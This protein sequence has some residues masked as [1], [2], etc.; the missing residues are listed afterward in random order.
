MRK[1]SSFKQRDVRCAVAAAIEAGIS[2]AR[3]EVGRDGVIKIIAGK[4]EE[5]G[6]DPDRNEWDEA[7]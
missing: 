1:P 6:K 7:V 3:V 4:P 2:I 5:P